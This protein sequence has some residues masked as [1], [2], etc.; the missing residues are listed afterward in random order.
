LGYKI[1]DNISIGGRL[2]SKWML[3]EYGVRMEG[4][5]SVDP[6]KEPSDFLISGSD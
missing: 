5:D 1:G 3:E 6:G 2:V 4:M